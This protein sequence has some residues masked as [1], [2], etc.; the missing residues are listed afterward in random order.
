MAK[1]ANQI[2]AEWLARDTTLGFN[3]NTGAEE[4]ERLAE[5]VTLSDYI[6]YK[7]AGARVALTRQKRKSI[8]MMWENAQNHADFGEWIKEIA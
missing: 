6:H 1:K 8:W 5:C 4:A 7:R 3:L 2:I